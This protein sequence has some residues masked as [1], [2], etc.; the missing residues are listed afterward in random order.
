MPGYSYRWI[1]RQE[2]LVRVC[3]DLGSEEKLALDTEADGFHHYFDKLCLLQLSTADEN[4]ILDVLA[5]DSL[6]PLRPILNDRSIRKVLHAAEQDLMYFRR[7]HNLSVS[8]LFDTYV[9]AQLLGQQR[10]G[11]ASLLER[12]FDI[13]LSK[14][15]QKDDWSQRPLTDQQLAYAMADTSHLLPLAEKLHEELQV[16]DR[17]EWAEEEFKNL[18]TRDWVMECVDPDDLTRVKGWQELSPR[19]RA[20]LRELLRARDRVARRLDRSPFRVIS[21][22]AL[23]NLASDPPGSLRELK[24]RKGMPRHGPS[25]LAEDLLQAT[26]R[27]RQLDP[28]QFPSDPR[29]QSRPR[30]R[31]ARDSGFEAR[32]KKLKTWRQRKAAELGLEPGVV[33]PQRDL[34]LLAGDPPGSSAELGN[35]EGIRVWRRRAFGNEWLNVL[36]GS[37]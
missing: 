6:E 33:I 11:L 10:L 26:G 18:E 8:G 13:N 25:G 20:I 32:L 17:L 16:K 31:P 29:R 34:E 1:E 36:V 12:Y 5:L 27:G 3:G 23:M 9:A 2:D 35:L 37:P 28:S 24:G 22:T 4:F 21:N 30:T 14:S 15:N 7:D 19:K